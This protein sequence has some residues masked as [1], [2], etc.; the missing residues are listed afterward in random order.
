MLFSTRN[1]IGLDDIFF[2]LIIIVY[3]IIMEIMIFYNNWGILI[4]FR[5]FMF[6][7]IELGEISF[8]FANFH[9]EWISEQ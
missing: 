6:F 8:L 2:L 1:T 3:H 4:D 5:K 9:K 7:L